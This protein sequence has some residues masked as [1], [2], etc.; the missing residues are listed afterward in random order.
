MNDL[1]VEYLVPGQLLPYAN[2]AR[3]H[4]TQQMRQIERSIR[5]FGFLT[6]ILVDEQNR[7]VAGHGSRARLS[8]SRA[9]S[10]LTGSVRD[11]SRSAAGV[12]VAAIGRERTNG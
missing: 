9:S 1:L 5:E 10:W 4:S 6:A 8:R 7:V 3:K 11:N 12:V 2:N